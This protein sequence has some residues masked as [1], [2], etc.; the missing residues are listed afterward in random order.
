MKFLSQVAWGVM[1]LTNSSDE[2]LIKMMT[3]LCQCFASREILPHNVFDN[4]IHTRVTVRSACVLALLRRQ[5]GDQA[6][7]WIC[8]HPLCLLLCLSRSLFG[9]FNYKKLMLY[10]E[11]LTWRSV[12]MPRCASCVLHIHLIDGVNM[13]NRKI[14]I[15]WSPYSMKKILSYSVSGD[16]FLT[17]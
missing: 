10:K 6:C 2:N 15:N 16:I 8:F 1:L 9:R 5:E 12:G 7:M 11:Y 3:F 14:A 13:S 17:H 4:V